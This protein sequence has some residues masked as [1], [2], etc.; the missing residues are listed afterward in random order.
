MWP[1]LQIPADLVTFTE[2]ILNGKLLFLFSVRKLCKK[3]KE[4]NITLKGARDSYDQQTIIHH[5]SSR[6]HMFFKIGILKNFAN[7]TGKHLCWSTSTQVFSF[8][9]LFTDLFLQNTSCD[10][11]CHQCT[12]PINFKI[13]VLLTA[14]ITYF[15]FL[16]DFDLFFL[17]DFDKIQEEG[18]EG[19]QRVL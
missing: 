9:C 13:K 14:K 16:V 18:E 19:K 2:E 3:C 5:R 1:N 7:F 8:T 4:F 12:K 6:S 15:S 11:F 17:I 10:C